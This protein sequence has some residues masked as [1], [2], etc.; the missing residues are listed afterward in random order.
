MKKAALITGGARIK[1]R[2]DALVY[3]TI[4]HSWIEKKCVAPFNIRPEEG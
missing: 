4:G 2:C 1:R 3:E